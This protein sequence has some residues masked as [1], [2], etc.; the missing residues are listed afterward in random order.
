MRMKYNPTVLH[1]SIVLCKKE[2]DWTDKFIFEY[3]GQVD[4][5]ELLNRIWGKKL[6][7]IQKYI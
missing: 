2:K 6:F 4:I 7:V 3:R 1:F 5:N